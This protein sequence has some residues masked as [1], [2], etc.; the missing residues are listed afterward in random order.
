MVFRSGIE[1][2]RGIAVT[3]VVLAHAGVPGMAAGFIGVD[4]FFVISG[5]LITGLLTMELQASGRVDYW[6]FFARRARRLAPALLVMVLLVSLAAVAS[7]PRHALGSQLDSA[8][9]AVLWVSNLHFALGSFDYFGAA[10]GDSLFLHTWSL[11]VEEQFYLLW[12]W[13]VVVSWRLWGRSSFWLGVLVLAGFITCMVVLHLDSTLAYYLM[14]TRLW[15]LASGALAYRMIA[16]SAGLSIAR[17]DYF[18]ALGLLLLVVSLFIVG[19]GDPYPGWASLLPTLAATFLLVAGYKGEGRISRLLSL[20][21]LRLPGR[22]SYSWY[23]WHWPLLMF[24]PALGLGWPSANQL[25]AIILLSFLVAWVSHA[26]IEEPFRRRSSSGATR[27]VVGVAV[28]ASIVLAALLYIGQALL[29][30][31]EPLD[32][33]PATLEQR[34]YAQISLPSIYGQRACDQWYHSDD[35]VPCEIPTGSNRNG[36][37][38]LIADSVGAQWVPA[39]EHAARMQKRRLV[40][41]TKSACPFVDEPVFY[42][43]I[44]RIYTECTVWRERAIEYAIQLRPDAVVVGSTANYGFS[45]IQWVEGTVRLLDRLSA[46]GRSLL[47]LAPTPILPFD[48]PKCVVSRGH[49]LAGGLTAPGCSALLAEVERQDVISALENAVRMVQGAVVLNLNDQVCPDG[50][51]QAVLRGRLVYRDG[52]HVNA[53]FVEALGRIFDERFREAEGVARQRSRPDS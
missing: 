14:P 23:L 52:Q 15:Q 40:V 19:K 16:G 49:D 37:I 17:A 12:P 18:G 20:P 11:G 6:S 50:T 31:V 41:L 4:V 28:L 1:G 44:N 42:E 39:L 53:G 38:L 7:L 10:A 27:E 21:V 32:Q 33:G 24:L 9:W 48:A 35:L 30:Y 26:Y 34:V 5:F 51:C 46:P 2:L 47:V 43:R 29:T 36:T 25:A 22:I 3:L 8:F 45:S 13:C